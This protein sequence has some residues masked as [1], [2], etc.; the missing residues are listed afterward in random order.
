MAL[1]GGVE[2][3]AVR[4]FAHITSTPSAAPRVRFS[5]FRDEAQPPLLLVEFSGPYAPWV[6]EFRP[7][8]TGLSGV[9]AHP[10]D[11]LWIVIAGGQGYVVDPA[12]QRCIRSFGGAIRSW[13]DTR[14]A[15]VFL[16]WYGF[17]ELMTISID[18]AA[19]PEN[20]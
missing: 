11:T 20:E 7:G 6:G 18:A 16:E 4:G 5:T 1:T 9:V 2:P 15:V 14:G 3:P 8:M 19:A 12:F 10:R 13:H 17:S